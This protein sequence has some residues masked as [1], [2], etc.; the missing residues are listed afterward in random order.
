MHQKHFQYAKHFARRAIAS[1]LYHSGFIHRLL[2]RRLNRKAIVLMYHRVVDDNLMTECHSTPAITVTKQTFHRHMQFL[3]SHFTI[4]TIDDFLQHLDSGI[5]FNDLSC[6]ITFDDGWRD[7]YENAFPIMKTFGIPGLIFL[8]TAFI[9]TNHQFWQERLTYLLSL[10]SRHWPLNE[11]RLGGFEDVLPPIVLD[12]LQTLAPPRKRAA[13]AAFV[14]SLK[15]VSGQEIEKLI[16]RL[17]AL[18]EDLEVSDQKRPDFMSWDQVREMCSKGISFGSHSIH[19]S[20]L[21]V[22]QQNIAWEIGH[23]K[24][25]IQDALG[26]TIQTFSYPNGNYN[27]AISRVVKESGYRAAFG[28]FPGFID[29]DIDRFGINRTNIQEGMTSTIPLFAARLAALW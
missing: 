18:C 1:M 16:S 27:A 6:L 13:V 22:D 21:T 8:P 11:S 28:T 10:I 23:S 9:G 17:A 3:K 2:L 29:T 14:S 24:T 19:H 12:Q 26:Q 5:P 4:L 25:I 20:I 15:S 7:N